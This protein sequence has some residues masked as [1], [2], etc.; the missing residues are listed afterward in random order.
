MLDTGCSVAPALQSRMA[1]FTYCYRSGALADMQ[2]HGIEA[3]DCFAV[4]NALIKPADP[5]F[6]GHCYCQQTDCGECCNLMFC[7]VL[8]CPVSVLVWQQS[9][10]LLTSQLPI[11]NSC[12]P[13]T[14]P[15]RFSSCSPPH[16]YPFPHHPRCFSA[17]FSLPN[18]S[19][20]SLAYHHVLF[21][22]L[23]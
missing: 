14:P 12:Q 3:I 9:L 19:D 4:D 23:P 2:S 17:T 22:T 6:I 7:L 16:P 20:L 10:T 11:A 15:S 1:E 18:S 8:C 21:L 5:L 13:L